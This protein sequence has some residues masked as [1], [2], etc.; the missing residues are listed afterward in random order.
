MINGNRLARI[1]EPEDVTDRVRDFRRE[2]ALII[3]VQIIAFG[4]GQPL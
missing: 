1:P 4:A 3:D 2:I